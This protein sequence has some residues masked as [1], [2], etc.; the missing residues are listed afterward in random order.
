VLKWQLIRDAIFMYTFPLPLDWP[1]GPIITERRI[2]EWLGEIDPDVQYDYELY[3]IPFLDSESAEFI[4]FD[5]PH[6]DAIWRDDHIGCYEQRTIVTTNTWQY[7]QR[8]H[9]K[10]EDFG[11]ID[12]NLQI[13]PQRTTTIHATDFIIYDDA[14]AVQFKMVFGVKQK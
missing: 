12:T 1:H 10:V 2:L 9:V 4:P 6:W 5:N 7:V 13:V 11:L 14:I 3:T 8:K